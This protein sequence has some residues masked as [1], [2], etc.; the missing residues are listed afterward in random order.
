MYAAVVPAYDLWKQDGKTALKN[1]KEA[2]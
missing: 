1:V 2:F